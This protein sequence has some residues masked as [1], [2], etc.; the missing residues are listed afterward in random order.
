MVTDF[1]PTPQLEARFA[2]RKQ[3]DEAPP[4]GTEAARDAVRQVVAAYINAA[5]AGDRVT[6][7]R[8]SV[9][10]KAPARRGGEGL[11]GVM[12]DRVWV[13]DDRALVASTQAVMQQPPVPQVG[14]LI[15]T[16]H[17]DGEAG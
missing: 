17:H 11:A 10:G 3:D 7:T 6:Q 8:L 15:F 16:L 12:P 4:V 13:N 5:L 1:Q 9:P 2:E 14:V